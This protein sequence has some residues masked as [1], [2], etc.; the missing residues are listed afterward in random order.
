MSQVAPA[1]AQQNFEFGDF[2]WLPQVALQNEMTSIFNNNK[3][4]HTS[5]TSMFPAVDADTFYT[6]IQS[7]SDENQSES[8]EKAKRN[9]ELY[10]DKLRLLTIFAAVMVCELV[11]NGL[12]NGLG[13]AFPFWSL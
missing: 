6:T 5:M 9:C 4:M 8:D 11:T 7:E 10:F 13:K 3:L 12:G 1:P 2:S